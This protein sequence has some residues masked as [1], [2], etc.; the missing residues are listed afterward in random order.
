M[1]S[2][3]MDSLTLTRKNKTD[4]IEDLGLLRCMSK[5]RSDARF[6]AKA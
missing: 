2:S 3:E 6:D 1:R 4:H 5:I